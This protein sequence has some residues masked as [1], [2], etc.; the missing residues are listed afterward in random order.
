MSAQPRGIQAIICFIL[1]FSASHVALRAQSPAPTVPSSSWQ[2]LFSGYYKSLFTASHSLFTQDSYGDSLNR[3]RLT[4]DA[5]KGDAFEFHVDFDNE[6]HFGN[7]IS[8]PDF[9]LT[10]RRFDFT[11]LDLNHTILNEQ[12][13][14]WDTSLYRAYVTV[15]KGAAMITVGRQRIAWGTA[16][17]WSPA[18]VFNPLNPLQIES[19]ERLGVDA[20]QLEL[21]LPRGVRWTAVYAPQDGFRKSTSAMRLAA[22]IHNYDTAVFVGRF[23]EN[24]M[25][26]ADFAGQLGGAGLRGELT[27]TWHRGKPDQNALRFTLGSDYAFS[28]GLYV[29]GEYFYNQGQPPGIETGSP[30]NPSTLL[31]F[32]NEIYTL[33]RHFLSGG[34]GR[35][36]TPLF[37]LE[38]YTVVDVQG[39]SVFFMPIAKY[40]LT[41]NTDLSVGGQLF[42][43]SNQGEFQQLA[44]LFFA[45]L[46]V[47]F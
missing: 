42:A 3:L 34:V 7:L 19:E 10:S 25:G 8:Q 13:V 33:H 23:G 29:V 47:H 14:Y 41:S 21:S 2:Y 6:A 44:N 5:K 24:W 45:Q 32:T 43:S 20:A 15:K 11:Y 35:D 4:L 17:F 38:A 1:L 39:P 36:I 9:A 22:T 26:G 46:W 31:H 18:D 30:F 40:N 27:Y 28:N 16:R 12:H 37:R